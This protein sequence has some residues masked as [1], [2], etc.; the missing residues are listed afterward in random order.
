MTETPQDRLTAAADWL[1][2]VRTEVT[3]DQASVDFGPGNTLVVGPLA[4]DCIESWLRGA[5]LRGQFNPDG[6]ILG[7][8]AAA[9]RFAELI[10]ASA[11]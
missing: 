8:D 9:L 6:P 5:A 2:S 4:V 1:K 7:E 11:S 3:G 10:L